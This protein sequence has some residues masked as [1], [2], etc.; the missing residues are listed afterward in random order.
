MASG[1]STTALAP[2]GATGRQ[3]TPPAYSNI[4]R[5]MTSRVNQL[6]DELALESVT[7]I[8]FEQSSRRSFEFLTGQVRTLKEAFN[9]LTDALLEELD[10]ITS[11][12]RGELWRL[13]ERQSAFEKG[14]LRE[15]HE[16]QLR[17]QEKQQQLHADL[18]R[19]VQELQLQHERQGDR[20]SEAERRAE[21][22]R[23]GRVEAELSRQV[24]DLQ[25]DLERQ[26]QK[27]DEL[28]KRVELMAQDLDTVLTVVPKIEDTML[29]TNAHLQDRIA[30]TALDLSKL[31]DAFAVDRV[32]LTGTAE[33]LETRVRSLEAD[34]RE[35]LEQRH[36]KLQ[37]SITRQLESMSRV[38]IESERPGLQAG[39]SYAGPGGAVAE[40]TLAGGAGL[41]MGHGQ[42]GRQ[43]DF[44]LSAL[45]HH[46]Q[47]SGAPGFHAGRMP[48]H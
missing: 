32:K 1:L 22:E 16:Q 34:L 29:K 31:N 3:K 28:E 14:I 46:L 36:L 20:Q 12:L 41:S 17:F 6:H 2:R 37:R 18:L 39:L 45:D 15:S 40:A 33:R 44:E 43:V 21:G 27:H 23:R 35:E 7:N 5:R 8:E 19:Q 30:A 47:G 9:T 24:Q 26:G 10:N 11:G 13:D 38:L 25:R 4:L 48:S 42:M